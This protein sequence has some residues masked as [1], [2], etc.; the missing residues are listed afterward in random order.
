M[1]REGNFRAAAIVL[2]VAITFLKIGAWTVLQSRGKVHPFVGSNAASLYI[3]IAR[4]LLTEHRF[5]GPDSRPDSKVPPAYP[6]FLAGAMAVSQS[7]FLALITPLQMLMDLVTAFVLFWMAVRIGLPRT[8]ILAGCVWLLFPPALVIST[9]ITAETLFTTAFT[10]GLALFAVSFENSSL[11]LSLTGGLLMGLATLL[12][13]TPLFLPLAL[14]P[15]SL[16]FHAAG[17]WAVFT[18]A[19]AVLIV[20]WSIRNMVVLDDF[21]PVATGSGSVLLQGADERFFTGDG[22]AALYPSTFQA[23]AEAGVRKP[24]TDRESKLDQWMGQVG[25]WVQLKRL[26]ERPFS[27]VSFFAHKLVRVWY[28][29]E[30][31][32]FR[33]QAILGFCA[34]LVVPVALLQLWRWRIPHGGMI[35][36]LFS[37]VAYLVLMHVATLPE[38]R[39]AFPLFP[40]LILCA[41]HFYRPALDRAA[42]PN[43]KGLPT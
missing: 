21:I 8:G 20:P 34:L 2:F 11:T 37:V 13:G 6:L 25:V 15:V 3:P 33:Q 41:C 35:Y 22:K 7:S 4:R 10:L 9:W 17:R 19:M 12:R 28:G 31:G 1:S 40:V 14:L 39:Y 18:A 16:R 29:T 30:S 24:D 43:K 26:K 36:V 32:A 23:A 42:F 5:N 27:L 38:A